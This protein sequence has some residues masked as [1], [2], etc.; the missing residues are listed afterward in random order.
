MCQ[1]L[2]IPLKIRCSKLNSFDDKAKE[3]LVDVSMP[4]WFDKALVER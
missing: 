1:A 4:D 3:P 2:N